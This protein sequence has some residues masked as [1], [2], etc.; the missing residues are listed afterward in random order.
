MQTLLTEDVGV[1]PAGPLALAGQQR[2]C[3]RRCCWV[4]WSEVRVGCGGGV[5]KCGVH[6]HVNVKVLACCLGLP[7]QVCVQSVFIDHDLAQ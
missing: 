5:K 4:Q 3:L 7:V 2:S 6:W 1:F